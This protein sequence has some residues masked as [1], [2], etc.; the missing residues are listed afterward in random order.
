MCNRRQEKVA[1]FLSECQGIQTS[2]KSSLCRSIAKPHVTDQIPQ[3]RKVRLHP[4]LS[5]KDSNKRLHS[6]SFS[7]LLKCSLYHSFQLQVQRMCKTPVRNMF[8]RAKTYLRKW[9]C[10]HEMNGQIRVKV[11]QLCL[12]SQCLFY[13]FHSFT[14]PVS[15]VTAIPHTLYTSCK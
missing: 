1:T 3:Y 5:C 6:L 14:H 2:R 7:T 10:Y 8:S 9:V 11:R 13:L 4:S 12:L 15:K